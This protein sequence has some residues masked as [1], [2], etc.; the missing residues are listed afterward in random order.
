MSLVLCLAIMASEIARGYSF[1]G[2]PKQPKILKVNQYGVIT[3]GTDL[4]EMAILK[5]QLRS[6]LPMAR[7]IQKIDD[8]HCVDRAV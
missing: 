1:T 6:S 3:V 4:Q 5:P 7:G 8:Y 2:L